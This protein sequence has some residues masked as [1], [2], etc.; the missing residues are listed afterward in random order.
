[1][2][3]ILNVITRK[4]KIS[5]S[6]NLSFELLDALYKNVWKRFQKGYEDH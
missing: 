5:K 6:A 4:H 3:N 1:M 2:R